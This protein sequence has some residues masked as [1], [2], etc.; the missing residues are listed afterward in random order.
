METKQAT[1]KGKIKPFKRKQCPKCGSKQYYQTS[2]GSKCQKCGYI[3]SFKHNMVL[4]AFK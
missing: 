2:E 4:K 1:R 3:H